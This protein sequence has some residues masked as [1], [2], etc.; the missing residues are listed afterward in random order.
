MQRQQDLTCVIKCVTTNM[1]IYYIYV[2]AN[3]EKTCFPNENSSIIGSEDFLY[4]KSSN[5]KNVKYSFPTLHHHLISGK[6]VLIVQWTTDKTINIYQTLN[7]NIIC[8]V[9]VKIRSFMHTMF[10][11]LQFVCVNTLMV[12]WV[13]ETSK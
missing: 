4:L 8:F 6:S 10:N 3:F 1:C 9:L 13:L 5:L 2:H 12:S 7:K 11:F